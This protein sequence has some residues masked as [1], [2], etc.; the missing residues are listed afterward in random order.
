MRHLLRVDGVRITGLCD[1]YEPRFSEGRA[2]TGERTPV[3]R[4]HRRLLDGGDVDAVVVATPLY[5]HRG[6]VIESLQRGFHVYGEKS[7]G[8]TVDD[9]SAIVDAADAAEGVF[10]VGHQ[11]RYAGWYRNAVSGIHSGEI[12][13]VTHIYAYWHR[14]YNWRRPVPELHLERQI[15][16]R[17]Y[18]EYSGGLLAELGSHHIDVANWVFGETPDS[19]IGD[20]GITFYKDGRTVYDNVQ[21]VFSYPGGGT[22]FFSSLIGNHKTGYQIHIYGT[23]GTVE[24][25]LEDGHAF[26]E[27]ARANSAIPEE[28]I[29]MASPTLST[30]GDM[31]YRGLGSPIE[32]RNEREAGDPTYLCCRDFIA[33]IRNG[34]RPHADAQVGWGA[35]VAVAVG[36]MAVRSGQR[37]EFRDHVDMDS[38][39]ERTGGG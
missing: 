21:A 37:V 18:R 31:P 30:S 38:M 12:G 11:Y 29:E 13:R 10:Q 2:I 36:N 6:H 16:W 9:C 1:I 32:A 27:P 20:G 3:Y 23:G 14:N 8:F 34:S 15:N 26:Y 7:M 5:L 33:A 24:L 28:L 22:L 17:L 19:V 39:S 35:A 4:D 25:T